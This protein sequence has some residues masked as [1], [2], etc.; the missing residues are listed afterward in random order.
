MRLQ[1]CAQQSI[2]TLKQTNFQTEKQKNQIKE[3]RR[4][5]ISSMGMLGVDWERGVAG[6]GGRGGR[7]VAIAPR[8]VPMI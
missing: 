1:N 3:R 7:G 8:A 5:T 4:A 6:E 2:D